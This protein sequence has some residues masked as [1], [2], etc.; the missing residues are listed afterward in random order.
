MVG[1]DLKGNKIYAMEAINV[2]YDLKCLSEINFIKNPICIHKEL[3][4]MIADAA[5]QIEIINKK[6]FR[7]PGHIYKQ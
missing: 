1:L 3:N 5:P 4:Q 2:L 6:V 7:E